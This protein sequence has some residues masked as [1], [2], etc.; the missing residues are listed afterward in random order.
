MTPLAVSS[1]ST[2]VQ[3]AFVLRPCQRRPCLALNIANVTG[4]G[5]SAPT[6]NVCRV[7]GVQ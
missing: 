6:S 1:P 3:C 2:N 7:Q 5:T 4:Q